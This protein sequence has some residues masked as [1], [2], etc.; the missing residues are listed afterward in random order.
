MTSSVDTKKV[1]DSEKFAAATDL[2]SYFK[3]FHLSPSDF[4]E[5]GFIKFGDYNG[6]KKKV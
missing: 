6:T 1:R 3:T 5:R 2:H 4:D